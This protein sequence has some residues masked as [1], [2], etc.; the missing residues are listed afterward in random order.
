MEVVVGDVALNLIRAERN[1]RVRPIRATA[2]PNRVRERVSGVE[3][4]VDVVGVRDP[5][6]LWAGE[7]IDQSAIQAR[8][9]ALVVVIL[10]ATTGS[11]HV[12]E[13]PRRALSIE[14]LVLRQNRRA[15]PGIGGADF[16]THLSTTGASLLRRHDDDAVGS[17]RPIKSRRVGALQDTDSRNI[18][19]VDIADRAS[20]VEPS[21]RPSTTA[22]T[23]YATGNAG[24]RSATGSVGNCDAVDDK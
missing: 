5:W 9:K 18:L 22:T 24:R 14:V 23:T 13:L 12:L 1:A 11:I 6:L 19:G 8:T 2:E 17:A 20:E 4:V 15:F 21:P 10:H 3:E 7:L 16:G